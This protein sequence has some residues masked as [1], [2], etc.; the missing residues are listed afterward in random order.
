MPPF[1][2]R[3]YVLLLA[4]L[5]LLAVGSSPAAAQVSPEQRRELTQIKRD[6]AKVS[7]LIRKKE[8]DEAASLLDAAEDQLKTIAEAAGLE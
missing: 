7:G 5:L 6:L 8:T 1:A 3:P 4:L 2:S